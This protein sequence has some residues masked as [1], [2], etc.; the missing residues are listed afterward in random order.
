MARN[1][2]KRN[3]IK[4]HRSY[5]IE[6]AARTL[7]VS[8]G[9]VRR[10]L[11]DGLPSID[12]RKPTVIRGVD[13]REYLKQK[14]KPKQP[15]PPGQCYCVKC[16]KSNSPAG[17]IAEYIVVTSSSGNLRSLCPLC[18]NLMHRRT[19]AAQ[20]EAIR[21]D[22]DVTVVERVPRLR[23]SDQPSRNDHLRGA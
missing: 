6:E 5:S 7:G 21:S 1:R 9:T 19:S 10:W 2:P 13:L 15:C 22:L 16:K 4:T 14:A 8:R 20:L 18:G 17:G 11:K 23:D 12:T 3:R